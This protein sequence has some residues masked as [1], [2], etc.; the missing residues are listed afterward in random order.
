[1]G[2]KVEAACRMVEE[3]GG[4]AAIG[5]LA[6]ASELLAGGAGTQVMG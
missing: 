5:S 2:P 6:E 1:M 3:T 4:R